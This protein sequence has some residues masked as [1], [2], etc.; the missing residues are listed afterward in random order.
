MM[1]I[2]VAALYGAAVLALG[3]SNLFA[4]SIL[5][6]TMVGKMAAMVDALQWGLLQANVPDALRGR[7]LGGWT[8]AVG[9]GWIGHGDCE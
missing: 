2:G 1:V 9:F 3:V 8:L 5:V 4:L 6:I 7:A